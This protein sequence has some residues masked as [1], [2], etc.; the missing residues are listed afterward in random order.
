MGQN[1]RRFRDWPNIRELGVLAVLWRDTGQHP[2]KFIYEF[3]F[4]E[5][6]AEIL[7]CENFSLYGM[8]L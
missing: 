7:P 3:S 1:F 5:P 8:A 2:R 6:S 4:L